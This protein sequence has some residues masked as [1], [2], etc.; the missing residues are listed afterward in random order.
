MHLEMTLAPD[1]NAAVVDPTQIEMIVLNLAINARDAMQGAGALILRTYNAV[2]TEPTR[3]EDPPAGDYVAILVE[4]TGTGIRD[5]VLPHVFEPFFTTKKVG[6]GSG[7]GLA[8]VLG[9]VK[10][11]GGGVRIE[12][13]VGEGTSVAVFLPIAKP[14]GNNLDGRQFP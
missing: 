7:L 10:Q 12:T 8:Q 6:E 9:V 11:S 1:L 14:F 4:D 3:Q 2:V 5:D 13:R